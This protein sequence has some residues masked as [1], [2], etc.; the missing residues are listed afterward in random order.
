MHIYVS[1]NYRIINMNPLKKGLV[2]ALMTGAAAGNMI[3]EGR[4][5]PSDFNNNGLMRPEIVS[6]KQ[7]DDT[8]DDTRWW[9]RFGDEILDSL[10]K[11]QYPLE[12]EFYVQIKIKYQHSILSHLFLSCQ[13]LAQHQCEK[14]CYVSLLFLLFL[15]LDRYYLSH[16]W[17]S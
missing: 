15:L 11:R 16:Y 10:V 9:Q 2:F 4:E 14:V 13:L 1:A 8:A 12:R 5:L 6:D 7:G 17:P 3:C